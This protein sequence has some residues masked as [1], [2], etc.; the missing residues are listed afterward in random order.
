MRN[1]GN[2]ASAFQRKRL[3][4]RVTSP[5]LIRRGS[6][7]RGCPSVAT[8]QPCACN[9]VPSGGSLNTR[10]GHDEHTPEETSGWEDRQPLRLSV[11]GLGREGRSGVRPGPTAAE[12]VVGRRRQ[13][14]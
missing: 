1:S 7:R 9:V 10:G 5:V 12:R 13:G 11:L 4:T 8:D 6:Y 14:V 2:R 3:S